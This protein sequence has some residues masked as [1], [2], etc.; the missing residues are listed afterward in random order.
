MS[1]PPDRTKVS[2]PQQLSHQ[3]TSSIAPSLVLCGASTQNSFNHVFL[4]I[5]KQNECFCLKKP[6]LESLQI[7]FSLWGF[8]RQKKLK[9]FTA[10]RASECI[11][12]Q[13]TASLCREICSMEIYSQAIMIVAHY[14]QAS[15]HQG[16]HQT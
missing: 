8:R 9:E 5:K 16:H 7:A 4:I 3:L 6:G 14:I 10:V 13:D 11:L 1:T 12:E 2:S 15:Y